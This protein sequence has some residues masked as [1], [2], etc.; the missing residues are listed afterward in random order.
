[1]RAPPFDQWRTTRFHDIELTVPPGLA[2]A[3]GQGVEGDVSV[4]EGGGVRLVL[5]RSPFADPVT[6]HRAKPQY[7]HRRERIAGELTDVVSFS[8]SDGGMVVASRLA[9]PCTVTVHLA[10]PADIDVGLQIIRSIASSSTE[11]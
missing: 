2:P 11:S 4:L 1:M 3:D 5:D 6:G 10:D 9:V 7:Q 8:N